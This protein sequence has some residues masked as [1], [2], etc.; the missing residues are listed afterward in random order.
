MVT[1]AN[2]NNGLAHRRDGTTALKPYI[3]MK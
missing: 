2:Y 3:I 1:F